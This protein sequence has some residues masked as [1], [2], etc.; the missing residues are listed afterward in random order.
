[1]SL[2]FRK[3]ESIFLGK[4]KLRSYQFN[5]MFK[6]LQVYFLNWHWILLFKIDALVLSKNMPNEYV[7]KHFWDHNYHCFQNTQIL[8]KSLQNAFTSGK[9][10]N[11]FLDKNKWPTNTQWDIL[12]F[13]NKIN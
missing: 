3:W 2:G 5:W 1:M 13:P 7:L 12:T 4:A 8:T 6:N 9:R 11:Q 10:S